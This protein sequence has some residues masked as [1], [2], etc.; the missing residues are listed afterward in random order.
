MGQ[1]GHFILGSKHH[2]YAANRV[3]KTKFLHLGKTSAQLKS[4]VAIDARMRDGF[5]EGNL[6]R[7]LRNRIVALT[8]FIEADVHLLDFVLQIGGPL[9]QQICQARRRSDINQRRAIFFLEFLRVA[10]LLGREAHACYSF[11][12]LQRKN[13]HS[14]PLR[15]Y[16]DL[17]PPR[18]P[19]FWF[20]AIEIEPIRTGSQDSRDARFYRIAIRFAQAYT[21]SRNSDP[22]GLMERQPTASGA[23]P[24]LS[25]S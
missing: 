22:L 14:T 20:V 4:S 15:I 23:T 7:P 1:R 17:L 2:A 10:E 5:V 16:P 6:R 13:T 19:L 18:I 21:R 8:A 11:I 12:S 24:W 25:Q 3:R 9:H